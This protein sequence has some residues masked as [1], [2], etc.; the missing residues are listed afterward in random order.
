MSQNP[1]TLTG[2]RNAFKGIRS[3]R[4][5]LTC[6]FPPGVGQGWGGEEKIYVR[7]L[8]LPGSDIG[9]IPVSYQGR[10]VKFSGER[11]FGEWS[12]VVYDSSTKD[13]RRQLEKWMQL[14]DDAETHKQNHNVTSLAPW[15]LNYG[16]DS[17]GTHGGFQGPN[18]A[19]QVK[20][21]GCWPSNISPIDLAHD[22]YDSFAEFSLTIAYDYHI[23]M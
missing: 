15:L 8:S 21:F 18:T 1:N 13:I 10:V 19:R 11:Q 4:Y 7:A 14:M 12:M 9:Q 22:S 5:T 16:D 6:P 2:F 17:N 3:N 20:L 23:F